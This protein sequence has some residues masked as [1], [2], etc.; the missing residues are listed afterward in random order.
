MSW[1]VLLMELPA[2]AQCMKQVPLDYRTDSLGDR[3]LLASRLEEALPGVEFEDPSWGAINGDGFS[4]QIDLG[5]QSEVDSVTLHV[6]GGGSDAFKTIWDATR[7]LG[8]RA[9][10]V[11][12]GELLNFSQDGDEIRVRRG[13]DHD[14]VLDSEDS[15]F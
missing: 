3:A 5:E 9:L 15:V 13:L 7:A 12:T 10:D 2:E 4:I 6:Q 8:V 11:T 14:V 1:Q